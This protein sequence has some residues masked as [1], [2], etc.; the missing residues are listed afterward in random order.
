MIYCAGRE[1]AID[2]RRVK[3]VF[4]EMKRNNVQPTARTINAAIHSFAYA[5]P[6]QLEAFILPP[7]PPPAS[8]VAGDAEKA[9][10][11]KDKKEKEKEKEE[12]VSLWHLIKKYGVLVT[13]DILFDLLKVYATKEDVPAR[14]NKVDGVVDADGAG[15]PKTERRQLDRPRLVALLQKMK[16]EGFGSSLTV[17]NSL[18]RFHAA[19][20][21][22]RVRE[23]TVLYN[24]V[25]PTTERR[26]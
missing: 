8:Q 6:E 24:Q 14:V 20:G 13:D 12:Q 10:D 17:L 15:A 7:T 19:Y 1:N 16:E 9:T 23:V 21:E 5:G 25:L 18:M 3:Q 22:N 4:E 11:R 26:L 2:V